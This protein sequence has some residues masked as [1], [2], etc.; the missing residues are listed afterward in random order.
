MRRRLSRHE[1]LALPLLRTESAAD[2]VRIV[3]AL[4]D[5]VK[6]RGIILEMLV[7][8]YAYFVWEICRI[9]RWK[10]AIIQNAFYKALKTVLWDILHSPL[11]WG[12]EF[13]KGEGETVDTLE[14]VRTL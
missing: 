10:T 4:I 9:R 12:F 8:D 1:S 3:D 5:E 2:L 6:P 7:E 11:T 13:E 14:S